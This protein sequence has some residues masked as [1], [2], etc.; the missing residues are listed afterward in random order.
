MADA[1][2]PA[3]LEEGTVIGPA[4]QTQ[5]AEEEVELN[6]IIE[7]YGNDPK[8]I[9]KAFKEIQKE[10]T[11]KGQLVSELSSV[12]ENVAKQ[13]PEP[14]QTQPQPANQAEVRRAWA[15]KLNMTEEQ[16]D[17]IWALSNAIAG[18]H[19]QAATQYQT[20]VMSLT[21]EERQVMENAGKRGERI[22]P[23]TAKLI[24]KGMNIDKTVAKTREDALNERREANAGFVE[25]SGG[26]AP[27]RTALLPMSKIERQGYELC[28]KKGLVK[29][30][31]EYFAFK[32]KVNR[33]E[34]DATIVDK[35]KEKPRFN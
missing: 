17:G 26:A 34:M 35:R 33:R 8:A 18:Q 21:P 24:A 11:E 14:V 15:E 16:V 5:P 25:S 10:A 2:N 29:N 4:T 1:E 20:A 6:G 31:A 12:I 13:K 7:K 27:M 32:G 9:A 3:I 22:S 19:V 23:Q 28:R 30:E